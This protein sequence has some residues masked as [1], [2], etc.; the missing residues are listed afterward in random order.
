MKVE[1]MQGPSSYVNVSSFGSRILTENLL[2]DDRLDPTF[3]MTTILN[4]IR[5]ETY[6]RNVVGPQM[7]SLRPDISKV[8]GIGIKSAAS[9]YA[10]YKYCSSIPKTVNADTV[11]YSSNNGVF[12]FPTLMY[13]LNSGIRVV[14]GGPTPT[15]AGVQGVRDQLI[16]HGAKNL[17]NLIIVSGFV[18]LTTDLYKIINDWKD[19]SIDTN[20]FTTFWDCE[21][22]FTNRYSHLI[23]KIRKSEMPLKISTIF[24][25]GCWWG[26]CTFCN[27]GKIP[28][29]LFVQGS[30]V[31]K[32]SNNIITSC[33][34]HGS[35]RIFVADDYFLFTDF[36]E[37]VFKILKENNIEIEIYSGI[38][39]LK[40]VTY[41]K[42]VNKYIDSIS[43]GIESFDDFSL[44]YINKG[45]K[46][47]DINVALD[48]VAKYC[49][50]L[51]VVMMLMMDLP[52]R[53]KQSVIRNY[54]NVKLAR[55]KLEANGIEVDM[56]PK[57]LEV[58]WKLRETFL[59]NKFLKI[60]PTDS[61]HMAGRYVIWQALE[62]L[63]V[64]DFDVYKDRTTPLERYDIS[65]KV[66]KSDLFIMSDDLFKGLT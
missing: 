5:A 1:F 11:L 58:N 47:S 33:R 62:N 44:K 15:M 8:Y 36:N 45:Y 21:K 12:D 31:E 53:N 9:V 34:L 2:R 23:K 48:N 26:K 66:L 55:E 17:D 14:V 13:L 6:L 10:S 57:L 20:D 56:L 61:D 30:S 18:D 22:D 43:L 4:E 63:G 49:D 40:N 42:K 41:V 16:K 32:V 7:D 50:N 39:M 60:A 65:G 54:E 28:A 27:Y 25:G 59:D 35:N 38:R 51:Q 29:H 24:K 64:V 37:A 3:N 46:L 19:V 52:V